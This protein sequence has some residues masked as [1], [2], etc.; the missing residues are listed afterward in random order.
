M[1]VAELIAELETLDP[2]S[3]VVLAVYPKDMPERVKPASNNI[4]GVSHSENLPLVYLKGEIIP[5]FK[6]RLRKHPPLENFRSTTK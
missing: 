3:Q 1:T 6:L 4:T 2:D 5:F